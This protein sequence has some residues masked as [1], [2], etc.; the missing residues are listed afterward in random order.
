[1]NSGIIIF[2]ILLAGTIGVANAES[3]PDWIKNTA[4]WWATDAISETEFV[5]AIEYLVST[6]IIKTNTTVNSNLDDFCSQN[7]II[8]HLTESYRNILCSNMNISYIY[9][10]VEFV[11]GIIE[12]NEKGFRGNNF[13]FEKPKNVYRIFTVGG[14]TTEGVSPIDDETYPGFL[15]KIFEENDLNNNDSSNQI[16]KKNPSY[17]NVLK[18]I[19]NYFNN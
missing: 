2:S 6:G 12:Y 5:N 3:V 19:N 16:S 15:Q 13:S 1:M 18:I 8:P 14:S 7:K 10:P 11:T 17:I 4:G 9:S